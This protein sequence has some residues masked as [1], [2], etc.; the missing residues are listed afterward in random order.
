MWIPAA[1]TGC[2]S[3]RWA[4]RSPA[5]SRTSR[6]RSSRLRTRPGGNKWEKDANC[7]ANLSPCREVDL[8]DRKL[9]MSPVD[10]QSRGLAELSWRHVDTCLSSYRVKLSS[11]TGRTKGES[12]LPAPVI[13]GDLV[14][15]D[16][17][18]VP[19]VLNLENCQEYSLEV[20]PGSEGQVH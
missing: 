20:I 9:R 10:G 13:S 16:L 11:A 3:G 6:R 8:R 2:S 14:V 12:V 18:M 19:G 15:L 4:E 1:G 7:C 17:H 5:T